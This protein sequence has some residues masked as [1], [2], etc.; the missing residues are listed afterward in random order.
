MCVNLWKLVICRDSKKKTKIATC[1]ISNEINRYYY[2]NDLFKGWWTAKI[3][4][5]KILGENLGYSWKIAE[6]WKELEPRS[7]KMCLK[8]FTKLKFET[9]QI[10]ITYNVGHNILLLCIWNFFTSAPPFSTC[11]SSNILWSL[12][13]AENCRFYCSISQIWMWPHL[14]TSLK[15]LKLRDIA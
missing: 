12:K 15:L 4:K 3:R 5:L 9:I 14:S 6:N 8:F 13:I 11:A 7:I 10:V 1:I 2:S